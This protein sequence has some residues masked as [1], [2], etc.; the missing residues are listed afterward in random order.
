MTAFSSIEVKPDFVA[1]AGMYVHHYGGSAGGGSIT[2]TTTTKT[3]SNTV[4]ANVSVPGISMNVTINEPNEQVLTS[5]TTTTT[6]THSSTTINDDEPA[7]TGSGNNCRGWA[8]KQADFNA[9]KNTISETS[10][11]ETK[12]STAKSITASNCLSA[13]QVSAICNLFS[14]EASKLEFAKY[15]FKYT[16]D[17]KNYFKVNNVFSFDASKDELSKFISGE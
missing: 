12:L 1:P 6:T 10:F 17:P 3:S 2:Q 11:E 16:I 8:M 14:F 13:D 7:P 4:D 5:T 15:A 9:A